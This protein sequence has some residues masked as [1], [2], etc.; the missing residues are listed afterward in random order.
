[1][2]R[3]HLHLQRNPITNANDAAKA[4]GSSAPTARNVLAKLERHGI[5]REITGGSY[6]RTYAYGAYLDLLNEENG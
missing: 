6:G 3:L 5:L 4:I 1:V 2:L